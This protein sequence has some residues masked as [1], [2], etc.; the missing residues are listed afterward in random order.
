[1][2]FISFYSVFTLVALC[3]LS[4]CNT[5]PKDEITAATIA[6]K[7]TIIAA[8][9]DSNSTA[10]LNNAYIDFKA[11]EVFTSLPLIETD[12]IAHSTCTMLGDSMNCPDFKTFFKFKKR[13]DTLDATFFTQGF[14]FKVNM[15]KK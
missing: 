15:L 12:S 10:M 7:W 14:T 2:R 6:G 5:T 1:M 4:S 13:H 11:G 3:I 9:R 8:T